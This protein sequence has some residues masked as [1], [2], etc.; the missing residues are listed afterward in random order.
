MR[1]FCVMLIALLFAGGNV[2]A[3]DLPVAADTGPVILTV[4]NSGAPEERVQFTLRDLKALESRTFTLTHDW[5]DGPHTY[6]GPLLSAVLA[7]AGASGNTVKLRALNEYFIEIE[8]PFID[9]YQ[10][11]LAWQE[12]GRTLSIRSKGPLWLLTPLHKY[13]ELGEPANVSKLIW[14]LSTIEVR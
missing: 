11:I 7:E 1:Q 8:R 14:Q 13:P 9:K 3:K 6:K 5:S 12:D 4:M 10:P 2:W